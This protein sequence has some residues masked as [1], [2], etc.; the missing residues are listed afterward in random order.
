MINSKLILQNLQLRGYSSTIEE[1]ESL[2]NNENRDEIE[3]QQLKRFRY[4]IWDKK[5]DI[6]GISANDI[7]KSRNYTIGQAYL[8]Y[9]DDNLVYFQDHQPNKSGYEKM[10]KSQAEK[11]AQDI[12]SLKVEEN[13]DNIIIDKVI[14][15]ILSK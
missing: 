5:S 12:I 9:I 4:E 15:T 6:N 14:K 13:T 7:I 8:I 11:A 1:I 3:N 10:T 2:I